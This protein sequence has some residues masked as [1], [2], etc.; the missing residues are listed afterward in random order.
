MPTSKADIEGHGKG[1]HQGDLSLTQAGWTFGREGLRNLPHLHALLALTS[2]RIAAYYD[3]RDHP[4]IPLISS[5]RPITVTAFR[6]SL[7]L[8]PSWVF[9]FAE[10]ED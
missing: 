8:D 2:A 10:A 4:Q 3:I 5:R 6:F 9:S 1:W 7:W